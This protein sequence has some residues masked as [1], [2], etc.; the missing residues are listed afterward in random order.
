M[1]IYIL[2]SPSS[3]VLFIDVYSFSWALQ[4]SLQ[5]SISTANRAPDIPGIP[6]AC[7]HV[8]R[9]SELI[10]TKRKPKQISRL[11]HPPQMKFPSSF[12]LPHSYPIAYQ[13]P[14]LPLLAIRGLRLLG[15]PV[16]QVLVA[17]A[18]TLIRMP[19]IVD[20]CVFF[21]LSLR[22]PLFSYVNNRVSVGMGICHLFCFGK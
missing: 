4:R 19:M 10:P 3:L 11:W 7:P 17:V 22:F 12:Q 2:P 18:G 9:P 20:L 15:M 6:R 5:L 13:H 14:A 21:A 1:Y 8:R 16:D